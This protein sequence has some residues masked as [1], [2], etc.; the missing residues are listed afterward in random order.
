MACHTRALH[1]A[2]NASATH[3]ANHS[4]EVLNLEGNAIGNEG[5][6]ALADA[7]KALLVMRASSSRT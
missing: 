3:E 1:S 2:R 5:A 4:I 6:V 7:I